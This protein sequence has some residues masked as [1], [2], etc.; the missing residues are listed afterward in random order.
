MV[1]SF[2]SLSMTTFIRFA[3]HQKD[4][5]G[6]IRV[7]LVWPPLQLWAGA[8]GVEVLMAAAPRCGVPGIGLSPAAVLLLWAVGAIVSRV[9]APAAA[10]LPSS[11]I[12][13]MVQA[14]L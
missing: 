5:D 4:P 7:R 10:A 9:N 1:Y 3:F 8:A 11:P 14:S 12:V 6:P 13:V 2:S